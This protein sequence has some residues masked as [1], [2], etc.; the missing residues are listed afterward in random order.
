MTNLAMWGV[1]AMVGLASLPV[2][3]EPLL[4]QGAQPYGADLLARVRVAAMT[5]PGGSRRASIDTLTILP[6][7]IR[8]VGEDIWAKA[9]LTSEIR[10]HGR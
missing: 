6:N 7:T 2:R 1:L 4:P 3:G 5:V 8:S 9:K 10:H